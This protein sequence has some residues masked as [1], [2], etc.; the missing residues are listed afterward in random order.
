MPVLP[1]TPATEAH[2]IAMTN[3]FRL[4][5]RLAPVRQN[6]QLAAAARA[7]GKKLMG[8]D[9]LSHTADGTTP[10]Q[11]VA[12]AGYHYCQVGENLA[13][14]LDKRGFTADDYAR[15]TVQ[16]WEGS[17]GHRKNMLLP[18][19]TETGVAV[20][21]ASPSEPKYIAV[22]LFARPQ[23]MKYSF[24]VRNEATRPITY[25]FND[26]ADTV[27]PRETITHTTCTP[28]TIAFDTGSGPNAV[29]R[30]ET[31]GG[32]IYSLKATP[33]GISVDVGIAKP[34]D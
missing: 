14:I 15:R 5:H 29:A 7:Y 23:S 11:R 9:A 22:Q 16:G 28:G 30:Y 8:Y 17:P 31:R 13:S 4:E 3:A 26:R 21:R 27:S 1:D 34:R 19:V 12:A 33:A 24:K 10:E 25:R 18:F 6:P 2:I 32:Q 20:V